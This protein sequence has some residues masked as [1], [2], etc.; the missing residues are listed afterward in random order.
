MNRNYD[1]NK[2]NHH[3]SFQI[4]L[5]FRTKLDIIIVPI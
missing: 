1:K 2:R 4:N 3:I 5:I